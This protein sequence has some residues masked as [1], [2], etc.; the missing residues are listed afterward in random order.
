MSVVD[1]FDEGL[2]LGA[3]NDGFLGHFFGD[4]AG[5]AINSGNLCARNEQREIGHVSLTSAWAYLRSLL[6][7]S[8]A[9]ITIALRP[10]YFPFS[11]ITTFPGLITI[12]K[13][14]D[15]LLSVARQTNLQEV[16]FFDGAAAIF[17]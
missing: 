9:E 6:P 12:Q 11:T 10:A 13:T 15:Q 16:P 14:N 8:K 17:A 2:D 4:A 7:S 1:E 5:R 3:L